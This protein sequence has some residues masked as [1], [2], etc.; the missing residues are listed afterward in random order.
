MFYSVFESNI[1][2]RQVQKD[3]CSVVEAGNSP[4]HSV[5]GTKHSV[6]GSSELLPGEPTEQNSTI[7]LRG[8]EIR[9]TQ[10][11]LPVKWRNRI[12]MIT[13]WVPSVFH[14]QQTQLTKVLNI[15]NLRWDSF[16][17][18]RLGTLW[19]WSIFSASHSFPL[20]W[21][22]L[23]PAPWSRVTDGAINS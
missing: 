11:I 9:T 12:M 23:G 21:S 22:T 3:S 5:G 16:T 14:R 2:R 1:C 13:V 19:K 7:W 6:I 20:Q 8:M 15:Q 17:Y 18:E 10:D 4:N